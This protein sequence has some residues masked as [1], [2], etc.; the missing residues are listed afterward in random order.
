V[1]QYPQWML[2]WQPFKSWGAILGHIQ[3][4]FSLPSVCRIRQT[5]VESATTGT[6]LATSYNGYLDWFMSQTT[7]SLSLPL[8]FVL[9]K[10][11]K[12]ILQRL[13]G[14]KLHRIFFV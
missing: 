3:L 7:P 9:L 5:L 8:Q 4:K 6:C 13:L 2:F 10:W 14:F 12:K 1:I 11:P